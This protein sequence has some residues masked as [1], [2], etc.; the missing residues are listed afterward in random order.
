MRLILKYI[1]F[2]F[3]FVY[4]V[5]LHKKILSVYMHMYTG[6]FARKF[7][8]FGKTSLIKPKARYLNG[9]ECISVGEHTVLGSDIELTAWPVYKGER[10]SPEIIIGDYTSIRDGSHITAIDSIRI[11]NNVLT[12]L[13][14]LITDNAHGASD[15][16]LLD[17]RPADR[18]L[19]SKGPVIIEDNVWIGEKA[20]IM[21]GVHIGRGA[22]V[23]ANSVVTKD[24]PAYSVVAGVPA[25]VIK[26]LS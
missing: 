23:A 4:P 25:K 3:S 26:S 14:V 24:V 21:P 19:S 10:F 8:R 20:S 16:S 17:T 9:L 1:G 2:V 22:I 11:G 5:G 12:G 15:I 7:R 18:P 13:N 6:Y